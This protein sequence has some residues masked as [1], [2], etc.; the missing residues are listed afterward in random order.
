MNSTD[1]VTIIG[2][3]GRSLYPV[4]H[5]LTGGAYL[6]GIV[7]LITAISKL[8]KIA[9][10]GRGSSE[11]VFVPLAYFAGAAA[12]LFLPT[13]AGIMANTTFGAGNILG[14][15]SFN[16]YNIYSSMGLLIQ[17]AGIIWFIR[18]C[19]LLVHASEPGIQWGPKGLVFLCAGVL[20]MN[21]QNTAN[22]LNAIME[23]LEQ[24]TFTI[25]NYQG[26]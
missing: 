12:L 14:Y 4:Q 6:I 26:Y 1:L 16:P 11:R 18:G 20:A 7:L 23:Q 2:N 15:S 10:S 24:L 9:G 5:L 22:I 25:K 21:F 19:V 17:T 3:I 13:V 8:K